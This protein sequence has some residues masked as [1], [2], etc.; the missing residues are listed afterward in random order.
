MICIVHTLALG[1][2]QIALL[3]V[4]IHL[5]DDM[6]WVN[7]VIDNFVVPASVVAICLAADLAVLAANHWRDDGLDG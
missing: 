1:D 3:V 7:D 2:C 4:V 6:H 5:D